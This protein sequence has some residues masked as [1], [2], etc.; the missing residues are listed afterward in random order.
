M[1]GLATFTIVALIVA[2]IGYMMV[3]GTADEVIDQVM[4]AYSWSKYAF[5]DKGEPSGNFG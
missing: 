2:G 4:N 3:N 1:Q 5:V